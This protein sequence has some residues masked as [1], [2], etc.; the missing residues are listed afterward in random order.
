M[1]LVIGQ[2]LAG[3]RQCEELMETSDHLDYTCVLPPGL[4]NGPVTGR[5]GEWGFRTRGAS[6]PGV[7]NCEG[8]LPPF[9]DFILDTWI[10]G[11]IS[12]LCVI[13]FND[14]VLAGCSLRTPFDLQPTL[15]I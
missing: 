7:H 2:V 3:M 10:N 8:F 14:A 11:E 6:Y 9:S 1:R 5:E 13:D 12:V 15:L 4:T